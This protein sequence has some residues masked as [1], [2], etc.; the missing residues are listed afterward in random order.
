MMDTPLLTTKLFIPRPGPNLVPRPR[1]IERLDA[2]LLQGGK[3]TLVSAPAGFGK[4]TLISQWIENGNNSATWLSLEESDNDLTRFLTY[5]I[6]AI[7]KLDENLGIDV[8]TALSES[9]TPP[10]ETLLTMLLNEITAKV[11]DIIL[12]LD[13]YHLITNQSIHNALGF[14]LDHLPATMHLVLIGRVDPPISLSRLRVGGLIKEI[15]QSNLRFTKEEVVIFLNDLMGLELSPEDI[16]ALQLRTEGWIASLHLAALS[17]HD[18]EDK[19]EFVSA[20]SGSHHYIIDYLVDEVKSRQPEE[21]QT[22]LCRTSILDHLCAPLCDAVLEISNSNEILLLLERANLF[23]IP[24]DDERRWYR[25]HHLFGDF[26]RQ[27]LQENQSERIHELHLRAAGWY[28]QN[29][30][31]DE[32]IDHALTAE[33]FEGAAILVE[34]SAEQMLEHS[35]LAKLMRLVDALPDEHVVTHPRLCVYHAWALRLSGSRFEKVESRVHDAEQALEKHGW[36]LSEKKSVEKSAL[37]EEDAHRL[38]GHIYA[39]RAFQA[40]FRD[41]IPRVIELAEQAKTYQLEESF[42]R[43]S[44]GFVLGWA[45]RFSGDLEAANQAFGEAKAISLASGNIYMA[46][47]VMCRDAYGQ[48][49]GGKLHQATESFQKAVQIATREDRRHLPVAGYAYVYLAVVHHEWNDLET[50]AQYALEGIDL[51]QRVGYIMDQV[52]GFSNLVRSR[53]AQGDLDGA[54]D[55]CQNARRLSQRM[56]GYVYAR[57]WVED[58]Q[59]RLWISERKLDALARW[60]QESELSVDDELSFMRDVEHIILARALVGLGRE[61]PS[62]SHIEEA[63]SLLA[64]LQEMTMAAG[65]NGKAIEILVLQALALQLMGNDDDALRTLERA[66][67]LAEPEVYVR[68]FVDEGAPMAELLH[69]AASRGIA[70]DY[71]HKLLAAFSPGDE[72]VQFPVSQQLVEPL[73]KRELQVLRMLNTELSGPDI[74]SELSVSLNTMRTHTKNIYSKLNVNNRRAAISKAFELNLL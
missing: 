67:S 59:V 37:S 53:L 69:L 24:L 6:A 30:Y 2:G 20:F 17:L 63:L 68:T 16:T 62:S 61:Q 57:R 56:G 13:D 26:L 33:D 51:C 11:I 25:Y 21:I 22:F 44:I 50:A 73:S 8:Q 43:S 38:M 4:T 55:A 27:C 10:F 74:A 41:Q 65:W 34:Q 31:I 5:F 28:E 71:V 19:K 36:Y 49:M 35:E 1:L 48:V 18:R 14:L 32:A 47:A 70:T 39:L 29:G 9:Q 64:R 12:V 3:L 15:R 46:V 52:V 72:I 23:L 40:L 54:R 58:C 7:Q 45:Y 42:V 60:I 66:L